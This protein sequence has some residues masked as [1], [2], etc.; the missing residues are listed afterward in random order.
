MQSSTSNESN[1]LDS[2]EAYELDEL[3]FTNPGRIYSMLQGVEVNDIV[4]CLEREQ[5][6]N[7]GIKI[8]KH[9]SRKRRIQKEVTQLIEDLCVVPDA[10][11]QCNNSVCNICF[12]S[13]VDTNT[14]MTLRCEGRHRF[15]NTCIT[16]W[17]ENRR[18]DY[19]TL[20]CPVCRE[21]VEIQTTP[22]NESYEDSMLFHVHSREPANATLP[23]T[24]EVERFTS[25]HQHTIIR[26]PPL[27]RIPRRVTPHRLVFHSLYPSTLTSRMVRWTNLP[28]FPDMYLH[29]PTLSYRDNGLTGALRVAIEALT[30][31]N[32]GW[33]VKTNLDLN[34]IKLNTSLREKRNRRLNQLDIVLP[35]QPVSKSRK[36]KR[37]EFRTSIPFRWNRNM[38]HTKG[39][40]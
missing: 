24:I 34:K 25:P 14:S 37:I 40:R 29:A 7:I 4:D 28:R 30:S 17:F 10:D 13:C 21:D 39:R 12:E 2:M 22:L 15:C 8:L 20:S 35:R 27:I 33:Y 32:S 11:S 16:K 18:I 9:V 36:Q 3:Y 26:P 6:L 5:L 1:P 19:Q 38:Y 31:T 23:H